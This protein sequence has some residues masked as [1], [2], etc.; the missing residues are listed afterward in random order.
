MNEWIN[1]RQPPRSDVKSEF[2][3]IV[4]VLSHGEISDSKFSF[5]HFEWKD[6]DSSGWINGV[7]AWRIK[8][9]Q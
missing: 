2:S 1:D 9:N 5:K 6:L 8:K 4:E 7:I 3:D